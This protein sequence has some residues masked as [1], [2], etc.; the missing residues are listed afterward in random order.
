[1]EPKLWMVLQMSDKDIA[2]A[3]YQG[4]FGGLTGTGMSATIG[5]YHEQRKNIY[6]R[7]MEHGF[8]TTCIF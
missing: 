8:Q 7:N 1:M 6:E 2:S 4:A 3:V 5:Q